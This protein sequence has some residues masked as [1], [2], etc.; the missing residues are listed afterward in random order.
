MILTAIALDDEIPA[1]EIIE[2]F[3]GRTD[4]LALK[5]TFTKVG[6]ARRYLDEQPVDLLFLDIQMPA[7]SGIDFSRVIA[8]EIIVIFTTSYTEY[9]VESY[10][11]N[12][13]DYLLKPFPYQ[14]FLQAVHKAQERYQARLPVTDPLPPIVL[15][16]NY[17]LVKVW[18]HDILFV[19]G[20]DN[21]LKIHLHEQ[22]LLVVRMTLREMADLLPAGQFVRVHRSYIVALDKVEFVRNKVL[23][24]RG[25]EI[26][27]GGTYETLFF[28]LFG[29]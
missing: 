27:L 18:P 26:P 12:A 14:R 17:G 8:P 3:A 20:L 15:K 6:A 4:L 7:M 23:H 29:K 10:N 28:Q 25:R 19:E 13:V 5:Q 1:L 11:L 2:T 16:A 22:D 24:L 9:A 21:Y